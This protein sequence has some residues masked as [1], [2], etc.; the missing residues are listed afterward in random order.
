MRE[1]AELKSLIATQFR[2][3]LGPPSDPDEDSEVACAKQ[4]GR[5]FSRFW[6]IARL[7]AKGQC[8]GQWGFRKSA[9]HGASSACDKNF[10]ILTGSFDD[11]GGIALFFLRP[12]ENL[13]RSIVR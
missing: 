10:K 2:L 5:H 6:V 4:L 9:H 1:K 3:L 11:L 8:G 13:P 7:E 12:T